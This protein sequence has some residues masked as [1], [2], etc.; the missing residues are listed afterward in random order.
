MILRRYEI[1]L[2]GGHQHL[3]PT[4]HNLSIM[5]SPHYIYIYIHGHCHCFYRWDLASIDLLTNP[6]HFKIEVFNIHVRISLRHMQ[7]DVLWTWITR[8]PLKASRIVLSLWSLISQAWIFK[9]KQCKHNIHVILVYICSFIYND[10][11][12]EPMNISKRTITTF[13]N[14]NQALRCLI[15][16][17]S[18]D[19]F[20]ENT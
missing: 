14:G 13:H 16:N 12:V 1:Y 9:Y 20:R 2:N 11:R 5:I 7:M 8:L 6:I 15:L 10:S 4:F 17:N 3:I 19:C 18:N